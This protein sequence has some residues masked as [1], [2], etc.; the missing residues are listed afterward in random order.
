MGGLGIHNRLCCMICQVFCSPVEGFLINI[1]SWKMMILSC[2]LAVFETRAERIVKLSHCFPEVPPVW[3]WDKGIFSHLLNFNFEQNERAQKRAWMNGSWGGRALW[4][5]S[6]WAGSVMDCYPAW[7]GDTVPEWPTPQRYHIWS[8]LPLS[9]TTWTEFSSCLKKNIDTAISKRTLHH[10]LARVK[11][12]LLSCYAALEQGP[13]GTA[14]LQRGGLRDSSWFCLTAQAAL[15]A[16][17]WTPA[18]CPQQGCLASCSR[19]KSLQLL[20]KWYIYF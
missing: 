11:P 5:W 7:Q 20:N 8:R 16:N 15:P 9:R 13:D 14:V 1:C 6:S 10:V 3:L 19:L 17:A 18:R 12:P 2:R 4:R